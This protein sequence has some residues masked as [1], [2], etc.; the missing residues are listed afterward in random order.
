M[1]NE[2]GLGHTIWECKYHR[3]WIPKYRFKE[4]YGDFRKYLGEV[5]HEPAKGRGCE[6]LEGHMMPDHAH[7]LVSIPPK[8]AVSLREGAFFKGDRKKTTINPGKS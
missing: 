2:Q 1:N 5:F 6:V 8:Y 3:T 4:L 7:M